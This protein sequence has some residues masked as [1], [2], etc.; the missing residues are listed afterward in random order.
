MK[1]KII[2]LILIGTSIA[3][4]FLLDLQ[5]HLTLE[6]LKKNK[7]SIEIFYLQNPWTM[8][9]GFSG[10]YIIMVALSLPLGTILILMAGAIFDLWVGTLIVCISDALGGTLA[11]LSTRFLLRDWARNTF[12][13]SFK[14]FDEGFSKNKIYYLLFLRLVPIIPFFLVNLFSGLT[15][16]SLNVFFWVTL[17]GSLPVNVVF[18]NAGNQ[19]ASSEVVE[20]VLSDQALWSLVLA[21]IIMLAPIMFK[22]FKNKRAKI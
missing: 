21:G 5:H 4:F 7:E 8:I 14:S 17:F 2:V 6:N 12:G 1:K 16:V 9:L 18:I 22:W 19:L 20:G 3:L 15:K 13:K 11:F 10:L